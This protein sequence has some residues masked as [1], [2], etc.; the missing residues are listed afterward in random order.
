MSKKKQEQYPIIYTRWSNGQAWLF[1]ED[2]KR[3][4]FLPSRGDTHL[5][6]DYS[7]DRS[8]YY[9]H[10]GGMADVVNWLAFEGKT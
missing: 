3:V 4:A 9:P 6:S 2:G 10:R 8:S 5:L 7:N 1:S